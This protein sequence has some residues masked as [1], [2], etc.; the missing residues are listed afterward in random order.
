MK[1]CVRV[2]ACYKLRLK[3]SSTG[4]SKASSTRIGTWSVGVT[5]VATEKHDQ[6]LPASM[7]RF[8]AVPESIS[9]LYT[10]YE[11]SF[12]SISMAMLAR[13]GTPPV[14]ITLVATENTYSYQIVR[15]MR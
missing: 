11:A 5:L 8:V 12:S 2:L 13:F 3:V 1:L 7:G 9:M 14:D 10:Q 15:T 4:I 6:L